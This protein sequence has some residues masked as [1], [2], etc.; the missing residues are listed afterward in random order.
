MVEFAL[1]LPVLL[2]LVIG[3][4]DLGRGMYTQSVLANAARDGA[5][6]AIVAAKTDADIRAAV[7]ARAVGVAVTD[8]DIT[9][10]PSPTR[11][12]GQT[13]S[14]RVQTRF[15]A[16]TPFIT[17]LMNGGAGYLDLSSTATMTVE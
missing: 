11:R 9:I 14:V 5:R 2:L 13:V 7:K 6:T 12:S 16:V 8:A 15:Y 10:T 17:Q 1:I 4:L 3:F